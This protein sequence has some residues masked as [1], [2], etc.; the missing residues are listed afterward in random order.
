MRLNKEVEA[1]IVAAK[2]IAAE[3]ESE[4]V[5]VEHIFLALLEDE[6]FT[7]IL[8]DYKV[9]VKE[10][11]D[12]IDYYL[13][14]N[15]EIDE[16]E[17]G[18]NPIEAESFSVTVAM[19]VAMA[20]ASGR[21]EV[22]MVH[23]LN[24]INNLPECYPVYLLGNFTHIVNEYAHEDEED[25]DDEDEVEDPFI[26][27]MGGFG[28]APKKKDSWKQYCRNLSEEVKSIKEPLVGRD[29]EI[30]RTCQILSRKTKNNPVHVGE[31]GVGK[32]AITLGLAKR[33]NEGSVPEHLKNATVYELDLGGAIAGSKY[34]GEFED[35]LKS[36]LK[37]IEKDENPILYI[38]E[39]HTIVGAGASE[40]SMDASNLLKPYLTSGKIKFIGATT[41]DEYQKYMEKDKALARRFQPIVVDEPS[42]DEA[43]EI[44]KGIST[45]YEEF[46]GVT[47]CEDAIEAAVD[48]SIKHV[49]D[50]FLPDKAIDV[51]DE[52]G[53]AFA[54]E[55]KAGAE[56][57][58]QDIEKVISK[59]CKIPLKTIADDE[60][61][62]LK[63]LE[64]DLKSEVFGQDEAAESVSMAVKLSRAGLSDETKPIASF[65]FVGPTGV[66]K[67][68]EAKVLA[69][70]MGVELV[71]F[72]MSE[73]MEKH[74]VSKLIGA[75]AG[76]VGYE[77]AGALTDAVRKNPSCVLLF[78]E[79]EK[80][81][82]DVFNILLQVLDYG[83]LTDNKGRKADF[84]NCVIIM[85][86]NAGATKA[87]KTGLG[88]VPGKS[89]G[90][91]LEEVEKTFSPEFRNRLSKIIVFN[92]MTKD[93][94]KLIANKELNI[95]KE[96]LAAKGVIMRYGDDVIEKVA[97]DG[98]TEEYGA[99]EIARVVE[100][101]KP[102]FLEQMLFGE[103]KDGGKCSLV[104]AEKSGMRVVVR[105]PV[106]KTAAVKA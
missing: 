17:S 62:R 4:F 49:H 75:P 44:L 60:I 20:L 74:T 10:F 45:Y 63:T 11:A 15:I 2:K 100:K 99:R 29:Y 52:A 71:R 46:H 53:A 68:E 18:T 81:H 32:T 93:M 48:L 105:H 12:Q 37:G 22:S 106:K 21:D 101:L 70:N 59:I 76:Y 92:A 36:V 9:D 85:T 96:K 13:K 51:I 66:G 80:A 90:K 40:G 97:E 87:A 91:I 82:P 55:G 47:Y 57:S 7:G 41:R 56:V 78:D 19:A 35:R 103:L 30:N 77:E 27:G 14:D 89:D 64:S 58:V 50:R 73:Y 72:D 33:I 94:A 95:L 5:T 24:S 25:L 98:Y 42:R 8:S 38:D 23:L 1:I 84:R 104:Y 43:V 31:P 83:T 65:L 39:I 61:S 67:T 102:L 79:I 3:R 6:T 54:C 86:S 88:F 16:L 28:P 69:K 34:R 26:M